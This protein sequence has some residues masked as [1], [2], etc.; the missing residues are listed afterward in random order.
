[1]NANPTEGVQNYMKNEIGVIEAVV[2]VLC[3]FQKIKIKMGK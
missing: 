3:P 1:V 2:L